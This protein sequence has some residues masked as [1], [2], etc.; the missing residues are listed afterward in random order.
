MNSQIPYLDIVTAP[1]SEP[2]TLAEV[3]LALRVDGSDDDSHI[4]NLI[5]AARVM[6]EE[7]LKRSLITQ[8]WQL[9]Y[10]QFAPSV[11][12]LP[13]GPV[14]SV[15]SVKIIARDFTE[16]TVA[17]STYY[18]NAGKEHLVFDA[19]PLGQIIKLEYVVG[20]GDSTDIPEPIRQGMI[21]HIISM[22]ENR[23]GENALPEQA[24]EAY[25]SY[26]IKKF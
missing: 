18:L 6:A 26:R 21:S 20:Y 23:M 4:T 3:K 1:A 9:Q 7:Y 22:Y 5:K 2:L 11:V 12:A 8:T 19:A 17:S 15:S 25:E 10:D 14:Q 13:R 24:I 16:T